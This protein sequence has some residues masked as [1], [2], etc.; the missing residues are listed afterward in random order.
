MERPRYKNGRDLH[1]TFAKYDK[2]HSYK[3]TFIRK[4]LWVMFIR[5]PLWVM[6]GIDK[7]YVYTKDGLVLKQWNSEHMK[8]PDNQCALP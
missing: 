8:S 5:E 6:F 1:H 7:A 4:L 3:A 2:P